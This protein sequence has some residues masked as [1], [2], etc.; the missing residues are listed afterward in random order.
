MRLVAA[1]PRACFMPWWQPGQTLRNELVAAGVAAEEFKSFPS[2]HTANASALMLLSLLPCIRPALAK[3]RGLLFGI[4]FGWTCL[5]ALSRVIMGAH[6]LT[7]TA[8]GFGI[9]LAVLAVVSR[10]LLPDG[11]KARQPR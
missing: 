1:D 5:V 4:G 8:V 7:D 2:G 10:L 6:Y 3:K 11:K 9:G